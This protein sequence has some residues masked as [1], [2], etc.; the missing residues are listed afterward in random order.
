VICAAVIVSVGTPCTE[1]GA[2]SSGGN[3]GD[4]PHLWY[5]PGLL[6]GSEAI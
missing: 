1:V 5:H 2:P 4:G 6:R 3:W